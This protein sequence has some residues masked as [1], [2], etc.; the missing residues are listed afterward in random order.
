[1]PEAPQIQVVREGVP[2]G[3]FTAEDIAAGLATGRFRAGDLAWMPGMSEWRPLSGWSA[4]GASPGGAPPLAGEASPDGLAWERGAS[5]AA[6]IATLK[7]VAFDPVRTFAGLRAEG[8]RNAITFTYWAAVPAWILGSL[9]FGLTFALAVAWGWAS[10]EDEFTRWVA[11]AGPGLAT[12]VVAAALAA[13]ALLLPVLNF[14]FAAILHGLLLPWSPAGG[15]GRTYRVHAYVAGTFLPFILLPFV[16]HLTQ[17][18]QFVVLIVGLAQVHRL[19]WWQVALSLIVVPCL[20]AF[21]LY[22]LMT[23][24][25]GWSTV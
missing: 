10:G 24:P 7:A 2:L 23:G 9:I 19:A 16:N 11:S 21:G 22:L 8:F 14:L 4:F 15:F 20:G 1:M 12:P 13:A 17:P 6:F 18:W 25:L 5:R 3:V